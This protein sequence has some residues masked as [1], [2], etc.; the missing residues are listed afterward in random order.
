MVEQVNSKHSQHAAGAVLQSPGDVLTSILLPENVKASEMAKFMR[1][2]WGIYMAAGQDDYKDKIIR[3]GHLGYQDHFETL[4]AITA[5]EMA[6]KHF[7][8]E[9]ELGKGVKVAQEILLADL[10][11]QLQQKAAAAS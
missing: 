2:N 3:I 6:M 11:A 5:F 7:G 8:V 4:M 1:G 9:I 10:E